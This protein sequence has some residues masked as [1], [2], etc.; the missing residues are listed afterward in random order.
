VCPL[1]KVR[2]FFGRYYSIFGMRLVAIKCPGAQVQ[3]DCGAPTH[4]AI[5]DSVLAQPLAHVLQEIS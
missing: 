2:A 3:L 5:A 1:I 4:E